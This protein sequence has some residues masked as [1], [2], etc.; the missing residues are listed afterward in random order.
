VRGVAEMVCARER[1]S[2]DLPTAV[3]ELKKGERDG[4]VN[5]KLKGWWWWW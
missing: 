5:V 2:E 4:H 1:N 3:P